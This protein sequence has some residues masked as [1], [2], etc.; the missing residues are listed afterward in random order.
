MVR[1]ALSR[2][3]FARPARRVWFLSIT[4]LCAFP[5]SARGLSADSLRFRVPGRCI[6]SF[7]S[8]CCEL[9]LGGQKIGWRSPLTFAG[10]HYCAVPRGSSNFFA[11]FPGSFAH[12]PG[13]GRAFLVPGE[14]FT[15]ASAQCLFLTDSEFPLPN[16]TP[17]PEGAVPFLIPVRC[18]ETL[19]WIISF[20]APF[21]SLRM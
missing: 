14:H 1:R 17:P 5:R 11:F 2:G 16:P 15:L 7:F 3:G 12:L 8:E 21:E 9:V 4:A 13:F 20:F 18:A 6:G 19:C 10:H